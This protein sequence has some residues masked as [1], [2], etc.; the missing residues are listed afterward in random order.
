[1][2]NIVLIAAVEQSNSAIH[3]YIHFLKIFFTIMIY[4]R[5]LNVVLW[6]IQQDL[7]VYPLLNTKA[8][9]RDIPG[10]PVVKTS[11]PVQ[12]VLV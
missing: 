2:H 1:M 12:G 9:I 5:I 11:L 4:H 10:C 6:A 8:Y 7:V 3:T